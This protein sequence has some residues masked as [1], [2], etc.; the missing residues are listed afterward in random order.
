MITI[1]QLLQFAALILIGGAVLFILNYKI[2]YKVTMIQMASRACFWLSRLFRCWGTS[3]NS[4]VINFWDEWYR[5]EGNV[6]TVPDNEA[7][8][9]MLHAQHAAGNWNGEEVRR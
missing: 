3:L 2:T 8:L 9:R 7:Y 6:P 4:G 1:L 5:G